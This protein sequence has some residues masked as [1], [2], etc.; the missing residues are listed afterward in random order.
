MSSGKLVCIILIAFII[1]AVIVTIAVLRMCIKNGK[2]T[3]IPGTIK[4]VTD[5]SDGQT[6]ITVELNSYADLEMLKRSKSAT[7]KVDSITVD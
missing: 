4:V 7:F 3:E 2:P 5:A 6:Y 1:F